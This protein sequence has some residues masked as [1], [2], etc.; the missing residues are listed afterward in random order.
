MKEFA[1]KNKNIT[2]KDI[3]DAIKGKKIPS[4]VSLPSNKRNADEDSESL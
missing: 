2:D 4:V 1:F 3:D